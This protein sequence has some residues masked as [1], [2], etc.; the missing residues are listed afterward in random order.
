LPMGYELFVGT[1][2]L[3]AKRKQTFI[4]VNTVISTAGIFLGVAALII[5][6]AVMNGFEAELRNKILG[7]NAHILLTRLDGNME[8]YRDVMHD[9]AGVDRVEAATPFLYGQAMVKKGSRVTGVVLRGMD[10][11]SAPDVINVGTIVEGDLSSLS[12]VRDREEDLPPIIVGRELAGT[13]GTRYG[14]TIE[15]LLPMGVSTPMGTMPRLKTFRVSGVFESGF[16]EYDSTLAFLS[17]SDMRQF[18]NTGDAVTGIEIKIDSIYRAKEVA[19]A[20]E[21]HLGPSYWARTWMEL[22]RN[23][24]S[25]LKLERTVMFIIL[26]LIV[27]VAAFNIVITLI[28]SVMEKTG[29]I[30]I[31]KSMG[32]TGR[33]I[34]KI[35][36]VQGLII[37]FVGTALGCVAGITAALNLE[38]IVGFIE[39]LF[40][41]T[42]LPRDVYYL[43]TLPS[44]VN[45][46]DVALIVL[47]TL[48]ICFVASIYPAWTASRLD[49]AEALRYE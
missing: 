25:A 17:L 28:M 8:Q 47:V 24:F 35:F 23:L 48:A 12:E 10:P 45:Y 33:S 26:S 42:V 43:S 18:L 40:G 6:L 46:P 4:S 1:R 21:E 32:A 29:D 13:L 31:L 2:Y 36:M 38:S 20:L 5:V 7:I 27:L 30:A 15:V 37:G 14:D 22:N 39:D 19:D 41:F 3:R 16:Y 44:E 34:M 9:I 11:E 49:P